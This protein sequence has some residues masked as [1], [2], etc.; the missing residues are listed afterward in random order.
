MANRACPR[1]RQPFPILLLGSML[2]AACATRSD[3]SALPADAGESSSAADAG[4]GDAAAVTDGAAGAQ[5][6]LVAGAVPLAVGAAQ[7]ETPAAEEGGAAPAAAANLGDPDVAT[8]AADAEERWKI[9][10]Q[11]LKMEAEEAFLE[12]QRLFDA[13]KYDDALVHF[14]QA[15]N[16]I[17]WAPVGVDWGSL[18]DRAKS[19]YEAAERAKSRKGSEVRREQEKKAFEKIQEEELAERS[20]REATILRVLEDAI[21]AYN[22][23]EF[24]ESERLSD[25]VLEL[26]PQNDRARKLKSAS[27][28]AARDKFNKAAIDA[29]KDE[30]RRWKQDIEETRIPYSDILT[31]PNEDFWRKV[32]D[33][34]SRESLLSLE[35]VESPEVK[36]LKAK[37][38]STRI[39]N[40]QFVDVSLTDAVAFLSTVSGITILVDPEVASETSGSTLNISSIS[41]N[42]VE[43]LLNILTA[44]AGEGLTWVPK[45]GAV[46]I[47]KKEK[48]AGTAVPRI[49]TVQDLSFT[50]NDFRGP[51][52]GAITP[53]GAE[54]DEEAGSIFG[55]DVAGTAIVAPEEILNLIK[56]N[57]A[58]ESWEGGGYSADVAN[59]NQILVIHTPETQLQVAQFLDDLRR[60][61]S[62]VVTIESRFINITDAFLQEIGVDWR[63]LGPI[64]GTE[65][66]LN[67]VTYGLEDN[68]GLA[69]DNNG[70][71][72]TTGAGLNPIAG[73]FFNDGSDGDVRAFTQNFF[74][75]I[76]TNGDPVLS[77]LG[78]TLTSTGG[79][80]FQV[81]WL[82]GDEEYNAVVRAV[83]K[84]VNATEV[85]APILTVYNTER[86]YVTV[87]NQI[88]FVQDFDVDVANSAFIANPNIGII[89]EGV[90]L[91]VRP[92]ISYDRKYITLEIQATVAELIQ[93]IR[94]YTTSLSGFSTPVT[95]QLPE[96][97]TQ[98]AST[99]VDVPDHGSILLAGL[100][101]LRYI[102]RT[103]EVPW[104][105]RLPLAGVLFRQKGLDDEKESLIVLVRASITNLSSFRD[106]V[107][108]NN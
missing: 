43:N 68:A 1:S 85:T 86:A 15:L 75:E 97:K 76:S 78:K 58:R 80:S 34:R 57:I 89:Q 91:D 20:R 71:G 22:R 44:Q 29:R 69:Q 88:S 45:S 9:K 64:D 40:I 11:Q 25:E 30:F 84:S 94:E 33:L 79:A 4:N 24:D 107:A 72:L 6:Q 62:T 19:A 41:N 95:F 5:L 90:V 21:S 27:V 92:T 13:G 61:T 12:G 32:S 96:L 10:Q 87:V 39:D 54:F 26:D 101:R 65:A 104:L 18:E 14:E 16:H 102:N 103:A 93:P 36:E 50:L 67:D 48:A 59:N 42:T 52:I 46:F 60:F 7:D 8:I 38:A 82:K 63:G 47:T 105:G 37:V 31:G 56:A 2:L 106:T 55:S 81:A 23:N 17:K 98:S 49:H 51:R 73:A 70:P 83:E 100:K 74:D 28:S 77:A 99:T 66:V 53:P 108:S 3:D 35:A